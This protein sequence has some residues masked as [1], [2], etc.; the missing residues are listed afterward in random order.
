MITVITY[1]ITEPRR[2]NRLRRFLKE[3]GIRSQRSVFEC[4]LSRA[5]LAD[6]RKYCLSRLD[7]KEDSVRIY[8]ICDRCMAR[9]FVQGQGIKLT[10]TGWE[11]V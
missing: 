5:E 6:I 4:R 11:I 10:I 7:L 3:Y 1:D 8:R 9:A 2:L